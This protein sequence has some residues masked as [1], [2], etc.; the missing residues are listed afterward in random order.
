MEKNKEIAAQDGRFQFHQE[1]AKWRDFVNSALY[2]NNTVEAFQALQVLSLNVI[3]YMS[4]KGKPSEQE[5]FE[6][7]LK[8]M[9]DKLDHITRYKSTARASEL[10]R[11]KLLR[12]LLWMMKIYF[13][14]VLKQMKEHHLSMTAIS[15]RKKG[16]EEELKDE[17]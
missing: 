12:E 14:E 5:T 15:P 8:A 1:L 16:M 17:Y 11:Q 13:K 7:G 6:S 3:P 2:A 4:D 9:Q 10:M